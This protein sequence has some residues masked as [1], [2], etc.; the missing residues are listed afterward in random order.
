MRQKSRALAADLRAAL[1]DLGD[2]VATWGHYASD[3]EIRRL[4][5][6]ALRI[7]RELSR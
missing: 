3:V 5:T 2:S 6:E 4:L 1:S 7:A